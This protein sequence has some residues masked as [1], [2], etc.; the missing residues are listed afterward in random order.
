MAELGAN[1][2][3]LLFQYN[4]VNDYNSLCY[5]ALSMV[6]RAGTRPDFRQ[7]ET[8]RC[9]ASLHCAPLLDGCIAPSRGYFMSNQLKI[10]ER[11][12]G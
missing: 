6:Q 1:V 7:W 10:P 4:Y 2:T 12:L 3:F 5:L 8:G 11:K 9:S